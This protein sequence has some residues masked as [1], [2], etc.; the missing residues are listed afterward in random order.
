M[1]RRRRRSRRRRRRRRQ[2]NMMKLNKIYYW[3]CIKLVV[4][5]MRL[6]CYRN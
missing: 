5:K 2:K 6:K 4:K 1:C 3:T